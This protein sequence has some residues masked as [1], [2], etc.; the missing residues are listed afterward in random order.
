M[1]GAP[2]TAFVVENPPA[3]CISMLGF[4]L[5]LPVLLFSGMKKTKVLMWFGH[6]YIGTRSAQPAIPFGPWFPFKL[7]R[8]PVIVSDEPSVNAILSH[9]KPGMKIGFDM[10]YNP[11]HSTQANN[12]S[13]TSVQIATP[14]R[15]IVVDMRNLNVLPVEMHRVITSSDI[16]KL[17]VGLQNDTNYLWRDFSV[18]CRRFMDVGFMLRL[19]LPEK[20]PNGANNVSLQ[21]CV[22][23]IFDRT[24]PKTSSTTYDWGLGVPAVGHPRYTELITCT[25]QFIA[26][27]AIAHLQDFATDAALD[28]EAPLALYEPIRLLLLQKAISLWRHLPEY[29]Y[30]FDYINGGSVRMHP[31]A[32]GALQNWTFVNCPWFIGGDFNGYWM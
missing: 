12:R 26:S 1:S 8:I 22:E 11:N 7:R 3:P 18:P 20:Y 15:L 16:V 4:I 21:A 30:T 24:L 23:C 29:W 32:L 13:I 6:H 10:E 19:A 27:Q 17:G 28:A 5:S 14:S 25:H 2:T 31:N 9:I